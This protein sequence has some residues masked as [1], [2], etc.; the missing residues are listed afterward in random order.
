MPFTFKLS[1]RLA[2]TRRRRTSC[3]RYTSNVTKLAVL[4]TVVL[5]SS[6]CEKP[7][8]SI[9]GP[10]NLIARLLVSPSATTV[11]P[12]TTVYVAVAGLTAAGDSIP[13]V[14]TYSGTGGTMTPCGH[15]TAGNEPGTYVVRA[16][17]PEGLRDSAFITVIQA[18]TVPSPTPG[19]SI[20]GSDLLLVCGVLPCYQWIKDFIQTQRDQARWRNRRLIGPRFIVPV[21]VILVVVGVAY[22]RL[23]Q[24]RKH[25]AL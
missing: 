14:V 20:G 23:R 3:D 18:S 6:G 2:S 17:T 5:C 1:K 19:H 11:T 21:T 15:Y 7:I 8:A 22:V 12:S 9:S 13:P 24:R 16:T 10:V 25:L 4:L